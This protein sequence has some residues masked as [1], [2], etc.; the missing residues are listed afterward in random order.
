[1]ITH[2]E[3]HPRGVLQGTLRRQVHAFITNLRELEIALTDS[4][5]G[6]LVYALSDG[7]TVPAGRYGECVGRALNAALTEIVLGL[8]A[9]DGAARQEDYAAR[10]D[11]MAYRRAQ[12]RPLH[13]D[14]TLL[15]P[16]APP[17]LAR[18]RFSILDEEAPGD[19]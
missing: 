11:D 13:R 6:P 10:Q 1:M 3:V 9:L 7:R 16:P 4:D 8:G 17:P 14:E 19:N 12:A 5:L 15:P 2:E 18:P